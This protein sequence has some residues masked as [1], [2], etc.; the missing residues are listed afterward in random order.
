[1]NLSINLKRS[2][3]VFLLCLAVSTQPVF[4]FVYLSL[5]FWATAAFFIVC[6]IDFINKS[7]LRRNLGLVLAIMY[8]TAIVSMLV[9]Y[10]SLLLNPA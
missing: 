7:Q 1:M 6:V 9:M 4:F 8:V 2:I 10:L 5:L 3:P